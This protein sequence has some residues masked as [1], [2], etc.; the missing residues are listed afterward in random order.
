MDQRV[1]KR[2]FDKTLLPFIKEQGLSKFVLYFDNL[3][4]QMQDD[5]KD[6]VAGANGL[7]WYGLPSTTDLW[8]PVNA[9]YAASLKAL[10]TIE[11][12]KLIITQTGGLVINRLIVQSSDVF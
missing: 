8:Q 4:V 11:H 3:K 2:W 9:G 12:R 6:A 7:L 1:C 10:I 5:F